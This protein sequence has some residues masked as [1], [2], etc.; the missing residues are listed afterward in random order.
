M[1]WGTS[2]LRQGRQGSVGTLGEHGIP[3]ADRAGVPNGR[4]AEVHGRKPRIGCRADV[5]PVE[6]VLAALGVPAGF[7]RGECRSVEALGRGEGERKEG[8]A[9]WPTWR[10]WTSS[11]AARTWCSWTRRAP[12]RPIWPSA[13]PSGPAR[14]AT[15]WPS[16]PPSSGSTA[17]MRPT[18]KGASTTSSAG[19]AAPRCSSSTRSATPLRGQ[20]RQPVLRIGLGPLRTGVGHRHLQQALRALGRGVRR[21]HR[22]RRHDRPPGPPRRGPQPPRRQLP[23]QGPR[24]REGAHRHSVSTPRQWGVNFPRSAIDVRDEFEE[25]GEVAESPVEVLLEVGLQP[26]AQC[27]DPGVAMEP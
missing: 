15:G 13:S 3:A 6:E 21:R 7:R 27:G 2:R 19:W 25:P 8:G 20:G 11:R 14:P 9:G 1:G 22:R 18:A 4:E 26:D 5:V 24:S 23:A 12:A 17:S 16:P 10:R